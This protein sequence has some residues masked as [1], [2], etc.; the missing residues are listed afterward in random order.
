MLLV[1]LCTTAPSEAA[2]RHRAEIIHKSVA[3][4]VVCCERLPLFRLRIQVRHRQLNA[5]PRS[6]KKALGVAGGVN[7]AVRNAKETQAPVVITQQGWR[8]LGSGASIGYWPRHLEDTDADGKSILQCLIDQVPWQQ[9]QLTIMGKKVQQPRLVAYMANDPSQTY[10]Y[11]GEHRYL[12]SC[13]RN[14]RDCIGDV[15]AACDDYHV[16]HQRI[17]RSMT[18]CSKLLQLVCRCYTSPCSVDTCCIQTEGGCGG[19]GTAPVQLLPAQLLQVRCMRIAACTS[20]A[21]RM[22]CCCILRLPL[23]SAVMPPD[24]LHWAVA[25]TT[26]A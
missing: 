17:S 8:D 10:R 12:A 4:R 3:S 23:H 19:L 7:K 1:T 6:M 21:V 25:A 5:E 24:I 14:H 18:T 15:C 26:S 2:D 20:L 16:V 13:L 9:Q 11:S 22:C